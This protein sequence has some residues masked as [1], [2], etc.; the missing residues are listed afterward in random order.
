[1]P[2]K[3]NQ[4]VN[5]ET[6]EQIAKDPDF[7]VNPDELLQALK[8]GGMQLNKITDEVSNKQYGS[9]I[10]IAKDLKKEQEDKRKEFAALAKYD[11]FV[12]YFDPID[13]TFKT[14]QFKISDDDLKNFDVT[15]GEGT[16]HQ[17]IYKAH[18]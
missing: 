9:V 4:E 1:M 2:K 7:E 14:A 10:K 11:C 5:Y 8:D 3:K 17:N 6:V 16:S 13:R 12:S 15:Y 18:D